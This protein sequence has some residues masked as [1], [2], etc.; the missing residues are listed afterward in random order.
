MSKIDSSRQFEGAFL[1]FAAGD[2]FGYPCREMSAEELRRRFEKTGC[3]ELAV[4]HVTNRAMFTDATQLTLFTS[5]GLIWAD[6][7]LRRDPDENINDYVFYAY[8]WWLYTQTKMVAG[9]EYA[10]IFEPQKAGYKS[11]LL[12]IKDLYEERAEKKKLA[13]ALMSCRD[14]KYGKPGQNLPRLSGDDSGGL[15]R[16]L[17]AGLFFNFDSEYAFQAGVDFAAITH[18]SPDGYL[19][20]GCY[21]AAIAE[22]IN[23]ATMRDAV[24][25]SLSVLRGQTG[26][27]KVSE[28][29]EKS[30][31]LMDDTSVQPPDGVHDIGMG[32][33]ASEALAIAFFCAMMFEKNYRFAVQLAANHDGDSDVCAALTGG[34]IGAKYG[35]SAIPKKWLGKLQCTDEISEIAEDLFSITRFSE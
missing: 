27:K 17:P 12:K 28:T 24:E 19:P 6:R 34:L 1:G 29:I 20:A 16:V 5:E 11:R 15:K 4:S 13:D 26:A 25:E 21:A 10:F 2:A 30:L 35:T 18:T 9:E 31:R 23:G 3:L 14:M 8:Q 32:V 7:V 33:N 22:L